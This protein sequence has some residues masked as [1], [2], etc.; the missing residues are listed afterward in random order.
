MQ[1]VLDRCVQ[2]LQTHLRAGPEPNRLLASE[3]HLDLFGGT[4]FLWSK[5]LRKL[6]YE[7]SSCFSVTAVL[8]VVLKNYPFLICEDHRTAD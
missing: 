6:L 2:R 8:V 7:C 1:F 4:R 5:W 3:N